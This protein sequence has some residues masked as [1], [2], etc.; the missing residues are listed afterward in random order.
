MMRKNNNLP[1]SRRCLVLFNSNNGPEAVHVDWM[2]KDHDQDP[3]GGW[4]GMKR[5][6]WE[7]GHRVPFIARWPGHIPGAQASRQVTNTADIFATLAS[8]VGYPFP[9]EVAVDSFDMLPAVLGLQ[10]E[11]KPI[12]PVLLTQIFRGE[13]QIRQGNWKYLD[14]KGSGGNPYNGALK[15]Y[16]LPEQEPDAPGQLHDLTI[17]SGEATNLYFKQEDKRKELQTLLKKLE[18]D[19]RSAPK[20]R[21]PLVTAGDAASK[22]E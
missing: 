1:A 8:A 11:E 20:G 16:A 3:A 2:R 6:A 14:H 13:F 22:S 12:R 4:W 9:D 17:A 19:G 5:D 21:M 10:E 7:G 18:E 15:K